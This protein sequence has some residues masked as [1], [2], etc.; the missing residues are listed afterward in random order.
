MSAVLKS[1][2]AIKHGFELSRERR[3][4]AFFRFLEAH[5]KTNWKMY[6]QA[7]VDVAVRHAVYMFG[8]SATSEISDHMLLI[9]AEV[10]EKLKGYL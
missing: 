2:H 1:T 8:W 10:M 6:R 5:P 4:N 7:D 3:V 9:K